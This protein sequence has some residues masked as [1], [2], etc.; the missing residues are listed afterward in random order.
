M[1]EK[2]IRR[3]VLQGSADVKLL[4]TAVVTNLVPA[5]IPAPPDHNDFYYADLLADLPAT[6]SLTMN[7][8]NDRIDVELASAYVSDIITA[9]Q[10]AP[11]LEGFRV[12]FNNRFLSIIAPSEAPGI[13]MLPAPD[14]DTDAAILLGFRVYPDPSGIVGRGDLTGAP[15][16]SAVAAISKQAFLTQSEDRITTAVNRGLS[17]IAANAE[18]LY[19]H[20]V[21]EVAVPKFIQSSPAGAPANTSY[22]LDE[23]DN[24]VGLRL[25]FSAYTGGTASTVADIENMF[26][27]T[28]RF[29]ARSLNHEDSEEPVRVIAVTTGAPVGLTP[30]F[31]NIYSA[32]TAGAGYV[33]TSVAIG[34][35]GNILAAH[36]YLFTDEESSTFSIIEVIDGVAIKCSGDPNFTSSNTPPGSWVFIDGSTMLPRSNDGKYIVEEVWGTDTIK[37]RPAIVDNA[38]YQVLLNNTD[39][40]ALG[41]ALFK[42]G[43]FAP[44]PLY[45]LFDRPLTLVDDVPP[46]GLGLLY[47]ERS[48]LYDLVTSA[49]LRTGL[50]AGETVDDTV[51]RALRSIRG[52]NSRFYRLNDVADSYAEG[53]AHGDKVNLESLSGKSLSGRDRIDLYGN[54]ISAIDAEDLSE[55]AYSHVV[56]GSEKA[57]VALLNGPLNLFNISDSTRLDMSAKTSGVFTPVATSNNPWQGRVDGP[58]SFSGT[59]HASN[60]LEITNGLFFYLTDVGFRVRVSGG[61][62]KERNKTYVVTR[63]LSPTKVVLSSFENP[64]KYYST[65]EEDV[66]FIFGTR[67][68][69]NPFG[70]ALL[71]LDKGSQAAQVSTTDNSQLGVI[72]IQG[73]EGITGHLVVNRVHLKLN[74]T[75]KLDFFDKEEVTFEALQGGGEGELFI[76][77][78]NVNIVDNPGILQ[79]LFAVDGFLEAIVSQETFTTV[80]EDLE[81]PGMGEFRDPLWYLDFPGICHGGTSFIEL[82]TT[83]SKD[84]IYILDRVSCKP[85]GTL[86]LRVRDLAGA[87]VNMGPSNDVYSG[88]VRVYNAALSQN[89][90]VE[91]NSPKYADGRVAHYIHGHGKS[92]FVENKLTSALR[93]L[94]T[95][96]Q[97]SA[98]DVGTGPLFNPPKALIDSEN[99]M[100]NAANTANSNVPDYG[101]RVSAAAPAKAGIYSYNISWWNPDNLP[102]DH[103]DQGSGAYG[104]IF[105]AST[106][107]RSMALAQAALGDVPID[108]GE[109][110]FVGGSHVLPRAAALGIRQI[111][112]IRSGEEGNTTRRDP[113]V[114]VSID[115]VDIADVADSAEDPIVAKRDSNAG[116]LV[117]LSDSAYKSQQDLVR[118]S[119]RLYETVANAISDGRLRI[120]WK[121][122]GEQT[123][124]ITVAE[125][126][127]PAAVTYNSGAGV[128]HISCS[129]N[130]PTAL[131]VYNAIYDENSPYYSEAVSEN[132]DAELSGDAGG[133]PIKVK[134]LEG[135]LENHNNLALNNDY[136]WFSPHIAHS[137]LNNNIGLE[138]QDGDI[139]INNGVLSLRRTSSRKLTGISGNLMPVDHHYNDV[140]VTAEGNIDSFMPHTGHVAQLIGEPALYMH[141][142]GVAA[143]L[144]AGLN[145]ATMDGPPMLFES[146]IGRVFDFIL[147]YE[148][149]DGNGQ[150]SCISR[151]ITGFGAEF[152][153]VYLDHPITWDELNPA[154][155]A[156]EWT[157]NTATGAWS[158]RGRQWDAN[159]HNLNISGTLAFVAPDPCSGAPAMQVDAIIAPETVQKTVYFAPG[160]DGY[161]LD[162][163]A[164]ADRAALAK[165]MIGP[166]PSGPPETLVAGPILHPEAWIANMWSWVVDPTSYVRPVDSAHDEILSFYKFNP[167]NQDENL[168]VRYGNFWITPFKEVKQIYNP[169]VA[170][171]LM[172]GGVPKT[173]HRL[174]THGGVRALIWDRLGPTNYFAADPDM[175]NDYGDS[176]A[177]LKNRTLSSPRDVNP[178]FGEFDLRLPTMVITGEQADIDKWAEAKDKAYRNLWTMPLKGRIPPGAKVTGIK[179]YGLFEW[180]F[181]VLKHG[182]LYYLPFT[183]ALLK[184]DDIEEGR[185]P[186]NSYD[187][188]NL[189]TSHPTD[190]IQFRVYQS[191]LEPIRITVEE[192][193]FNIPTMSNVTVNSQKEIPWIIRNQSL[194]GTEDTMSVECTY[195]DTEELV[196][197]PPFLRA[198][199]SE[200]TDLEWII[201]DND[202][203]EIALDR[204]QHQLSNNSWYGYMSFLN[205]GDTEGATDETRDTNGVFYEFKGPLTGRGDGTSPRIRAFL[206]LNGVE[207]TYTYDGISLTSSNI[208][209]AGR[210]LVNF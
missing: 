81:H 32:P 151:I 122:R 66:T 107:S 42:C 180:S 38:N 128:L 51:V 179:F 64:G 184:G 52:P 209:L 206:W 58:G 71:R 140:T 87:S 175:D 162:R 111:F 100:L 183:G 150:T 102:S 117:S 89:I 2:Y 136:R 126:M 49:L 53:V 163:S 59:L 16:R 105:V 164:I 11:G 76:V 98:I 189:S 19:I 46:D 14:G 70:G 204:L 82:S 106:E 115:A 24:I 48:T 92:P 6:L 114:I 15:H 78:P 26:R 200:V 187:P 182:K 25:T 21:D 88:H 56:T 137:G 54:D 134:S 147:E 113:A 63:W 159:I 103:F 73:Q 80:S 96:G 61:T 197:D 160:I 22:I 39:G 116:I 95:G 139:K 198:W 127:L 207:V 145:W 9:I 155:S 86:A 173:P 132:F 167:P 130:H 44:S 186:I 109:D 50:K 135:F 165:D 101:I 31:S 75:T 172:D 60:I 123:V 18:N 91:T 30:E 12:V 144:V 121:N 36:P 83:T 124:K 131:E 148:D 170:S 7:G 176:I 208:D 72:S 90:T 129:N 133:W 193:D 28:D 85:D 174:A 125:L 84:G 203:L 65:A 171:Y 29:G 40:G 74:D 4:A 41:T 119:V 142:T 33:T 104:A 57:Q 152:D 202:L 112:P 99:R 146:D 120:F 185:A 138:V 23:D 188:I 47:G 161:V 156:P 168:V 141:D 62:N 34:D 108:N 94:A 77:L 17:A 194:T 1:G 79:S 181:V 199:K 190:A 192:D 43:D 37:I 177:N 35:G 5:D 55:D 149:A 3:G 97:I 157:I 110:T 191:R 166:N 178:A 205:A 201:G 93:V 169:N 67:T 195:P 118:Y 8:L 45:V 210:N 13:M 20:L 68:S 27:I 10:D 143:T 154:D 153:R 69:Y 196:K 158:T